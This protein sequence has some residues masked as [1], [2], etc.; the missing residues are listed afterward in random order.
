MLSVRTLLWFLKYSSLE[1]KYLSMK[2]TDYMG[3]T[4]FGKAVNTIRESFPYFVSSAENNPLQADAS[5][6]HPEFGLV[7]TMLLISRLKQATSPTYKINLVVTLPHCK[8]NEMMFMGSE[9][10][11]ENWLENIMSAKQVEEY[12]ISIYRELSQL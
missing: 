11:I 12:V 1:W 10:E 9:L 7:P 6:Q 2:I 5:Y 8:V 4:E 3:F